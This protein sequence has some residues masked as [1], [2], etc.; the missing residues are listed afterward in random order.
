MTTAELARALAALRT[1]PGRKPVNRW[2]CNACGAV[3]GTIEMR[4]HRD[5]CRFER[6]PPPRDPARIECLRCGQAMGMYAT[7]TH[8]CL[9]KDR[10][11]A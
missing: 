6:Y 10:P 3:M 4:G 8:R 1:S 11:A 7:R 2:K 9:S 5:A